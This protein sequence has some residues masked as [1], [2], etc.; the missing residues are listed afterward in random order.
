LE[1]RK[2]MAIAGRFCASS[3]GSVR[4]SARA[5][6]G[7]AW[8]ILRRADEPPRVVFVWYAALWHLDDEIPSRPSDVVVLR[9]VDAGIDT[10][11]AAACRRIQEH[12]LRLDAEGRL[13]LDEDD[14]EL[15]L[16]LYQAALI[17]THAPSRVDR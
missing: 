4:R 10:L 6:R 7:W 16:E 2:I 15:E 5:E 3:R 8:F 12:P 11:I 1:E 17:R 13:V 9:V 14:L